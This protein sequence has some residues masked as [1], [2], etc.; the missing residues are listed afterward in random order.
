MY[1]VHTLDLESN[2]LIQTRFDSLHQKNKKPPL[3]LTRALLTWWPGAESNHRHK[4]FQLCFHLDNYSWFSAITCR[5]SAVLSALHLLARSG[6][7]WRSCH[8]DFY[9]SGF[10]RPVAGRWPTQGFLLLVLVGFAS[11][12]RLGNGHSS[13]FKSMPTQ[14]LEPSVDLQSLVIP[15]PANFGSKDYTLMPL[16]TDHSSKQPLIGIRFAVIES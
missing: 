2:P 6:T 9:L 7:P 5:E 4:D 15:Q 14:A 11:E 3:S 10:K 16:I 8:I 1:I 12:H 13:T